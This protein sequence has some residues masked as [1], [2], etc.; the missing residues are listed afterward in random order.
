MI[1]IKAIKRNTPIPKVNQDNTPNNSPNL[2]SPLRLFKLKDLKIKLT[3]S[4]LR[5]EKN[6]K[7]K[8]S[9]NKKISL[10]FSR[11]CFSALNIVENKKTIRRP[12]I[13]ISIIN[14]PKN[15]HPNKLKIKENLTACINTPKTIKYLEEVSNKTNEPTIKPLKNSFN[16]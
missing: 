15:G 9:Q 6:N 8:P 10:N 3:L 11:G 2:I 1:E 7:I 13:Y 5:K 14:S 12:P 4:P 16:T